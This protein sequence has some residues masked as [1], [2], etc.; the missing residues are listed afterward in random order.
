MSVSNVKGTAK[1]C[2][3]SDKYKENMVLSHLYTKSESS[4]TQQ[5]KKNYDETALGKNDV[6]FINK[7]T[8]FLS[9]R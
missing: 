2:E 7:K 3:F 5:L 6:V 9:Y 8:G 1:P 4:E